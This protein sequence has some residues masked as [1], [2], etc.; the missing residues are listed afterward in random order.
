MKR[1]FTLIELLVVIAIIGL[2]SSVVFASLNSARGKARDARRIADVRQI[3]RAIEM[4]YN[5]FG[6]YPVVGGWQGT[7]SGCY[8]GAG[9]PGIVPTYISSMPMDPLPST[10]SS[11]ICYLYY[12]N[13]VDY[14][15]L[16]HGALEACS[17]GS[18]PL[19][20][21]ARTGQRTGAIYTPAAR[22]W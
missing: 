13:G 10:A 20:D 12:S 17:P 8:G 19:Q 4:Y 22:L 15:I 2:L 9:I 5:D 14:K 1:G 11:G 6:N 18:C 16:I 3:E 21:P 7:S